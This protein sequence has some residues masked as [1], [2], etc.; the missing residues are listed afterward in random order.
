MPTRRRRRRQSIDPPYT[1]LGDVPMVLK[2]RDMA[3][4]YRQGARTIRRR[5]RN[6]TYLPMPTGT[7]PYTWQKADILRDLEQ[8]RLDVRP[9]RRRSLTH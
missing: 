8:P 4:L 6:G 5:I 7:D 2:I 9:S 1:N 3:R